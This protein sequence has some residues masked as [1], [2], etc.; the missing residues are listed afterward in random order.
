[1]FTY[2]DIV[3]QSIAVEKSILSACCSFVQN[4]IACNQQ[5]QCCV[6]L[7][8]VSGCE[9]RCDSGVVDT[10]GDLSCHHEALTTP[11]VSL[12]HGSV[13]VL[14]SVTMDRM[15]VTVTDYTNTVLVSY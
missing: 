9:C 8:C 3:K 1:V 12:S 6:V 13:T 7:C 15:S 10:V 2:I 11:T 4:F 14:L 5:L